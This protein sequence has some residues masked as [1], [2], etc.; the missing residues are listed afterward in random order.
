M[1]DSTS[2]QFISISLPALL[3]GGMMSLAQT[4][5]VAHPS[6]STSTVHTTYPLAK[7]RPL[8]SQTNRQEL[9]CLCSRDPHFTE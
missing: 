6:P 1:E 5:D 8:S 2:K 9:Q 3:S 7:W 4:P